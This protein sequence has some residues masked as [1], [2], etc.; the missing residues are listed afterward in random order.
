MRTQHSNLKNDVNS[1]DLENNAVYINLEY[2][3]LNELFS[4]SLKILFGIENLLTSEKRTYFR[5]IR[6]LQNKF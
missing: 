4:N 3:T 5:I 1:N 6:L 2:E